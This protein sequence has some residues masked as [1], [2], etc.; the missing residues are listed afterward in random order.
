M[1]LFHVIS[2]CNFIATAMF[3][4]T[5][6]L[7]HHKVPRFTNVY[8]AQS[9]KYAKDI[10]RPVAPNQL[11]NDAGS[12]IEV[13]SSKA[14]T[15][16]NSLLDDRVSIPRR[17]FATEQLPRPPP[18]TKEPVVETFADTSKPKPKPFYGRPPPRTELPLQKVSNL[19]SYVLSLF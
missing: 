12:G 16:T 9:R 11:N 13:F 7:F 17:D 18:S 2:F 1:R 10:P 3:A 14:R 4:R 6:T 15:P 19:C 8:L 5:S